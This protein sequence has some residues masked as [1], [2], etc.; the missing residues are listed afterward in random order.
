MFIAR[1]SGYLE[2]VLPGSSDFVILITGEVFK[3]PVKGRLLAATPSV[4][5][6][7][8]LVSSK[9][10]QYDYFVVHYL[11]PEWADLI[12]SVEKSVRVIW[13]GFG[14]DYY[15]SD[16]SPD[17]GILA[18]LTAELVGSWAP[19]L[20]ITGRIAQKLAGYRQGSPKRRAVKRVD[21]FSA[22]VPTDLKIMRARYSQFRGDY[23]QLSYATSEESAGDALNPTGENI[24][25][26]NS[27][28]PSNNH[29]DVFEQLAGAKDPGRKVLVPLSYGEPQVYREAIIAAG[30]KHFGEDFVPI[31]DFMPLDDYNRLISSCSFVIMG[32]R[33]QQGLGN[34]LAALLS[35]STLIL[36]RANPVHEYLSQLGVRLTTLDDLSH[37]TIQET[38]LEP[39]DVIANRALVE[40]SWARS[41]V[42]ENLRNTFNAS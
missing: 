7:L 31:L 9:V 4:D 10:N 12:P 42:L 36:D 22:P 20:R 30:V 1:L 15:G 39:D 29:L 6:I 5:E 13:S 40:Q 28:S 17:D 21:A 11:I 3:H 41:T 8:A 14:G 33:R 32:H 18:P 24:L 34:I 23:V 38:R 2:Q 27:A 25:V 37:R 26:G 19:K 35:G 16:I